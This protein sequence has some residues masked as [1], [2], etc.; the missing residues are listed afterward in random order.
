MATSKHDDYPVFEFKESPAFE[1]WLSKN[2][3]KSEGTWLKI[4]KAKT[5]ITTISYM[6]AIDIALCYGWIDGLRRG[7]DETYFL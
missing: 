5:G 7:L 3:E 1:K 2:F 6:E 4:A